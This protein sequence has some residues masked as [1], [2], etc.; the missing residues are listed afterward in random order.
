MKGNENLGSLCATSGCGWACCDFGSKGRII[1]LPEEYE[2]ANG[3]L[4][5]LLVVDEEY[6]GG[7][8]VK[9]RAEDK[10]ICDGGYKPIQCIIY[11][12]WIRSGELVT[13]SQ[14]CPLKSSV[15]P[16][17]SKDALKIIGDYKAEHP[18]VDID[19]FLDEAEV[20]RYV[21]LK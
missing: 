3:N 17:H 6:N 4:D 16:P 7:K 21:I 9:C 8:R 12:L 20:D 15:L 11:P 14:K 1:M 10:S 19:R 5:H 13:R 18:T 2:N